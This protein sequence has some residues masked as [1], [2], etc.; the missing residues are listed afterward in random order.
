M[1]SAN[2]AILASYLKMLKL[3]GLAQGYRSVIREAEAANLPYSEFLQA[4]LEQE[5]GLREQKRIQRKLKA[6]KFPLTKTLESFDFSA[7]PGIPANRI[8]SLADCSY[9]RQKENL[10]F[11]GNPGTGK[12]HLAIA[13]ATIACQKGFSV[14]F[15]RAITLANELMA[16]QK[17]LSLG[18]L[19]KRWL[20]YDLTVID[21]L[22]YIPFSAEAADLMFHFVSSRHEAGSTIITTNLDFSR[23][24]EIFGEEGLTAAVIDRLVHKAHII[25]TNGDS[26]RFKESLRR[27]ETEAC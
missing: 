2:E 4:C 16:A 20:R 14:R 9:I 8:L 19:E 5:L 3:P 21:E 1:N 12:T 6:A 22:G 11:A 26:F 17:E 10:I 18:R 23:W 13:L 7:Q 24:T 27:R 15:Y 25:A